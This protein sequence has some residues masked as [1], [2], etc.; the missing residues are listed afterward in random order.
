MNI[1]AKD[2]ESGTNHN[3]CFTRLTMD[4][5]YLNSALEEAITVSK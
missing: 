4:S 3:L 5:E 2:M 1:L